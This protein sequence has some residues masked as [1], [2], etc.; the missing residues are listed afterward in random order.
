MID[1]TELKNCCSYEESVINHFAED[2]ELG[3]IMLND[4]IKEG[5]IDEIRTVWHRIQEAKKRKVS[6]S[7]STENE[8]LEAVSA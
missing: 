3:E 1:I 2:P 7:L 5:D 4:A 6:Q 8:K